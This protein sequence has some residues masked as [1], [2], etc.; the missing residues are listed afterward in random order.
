MSRRD[1]GVP[2]DAPEGTVSCGPLR[3]EPDGSWFHGA[4]F[5]GRDHEP[6]SSLHEL[7]STVGIVAA[8]L[9]DALKEACD[10]LHEWGHVSAA[11]RGRDVLRR[12]QRWQTSRRW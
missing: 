3:R 10:A 8:G 5:L 6:V 7:E 11:Q 9:G 1:V 2:G 4:S 12:F